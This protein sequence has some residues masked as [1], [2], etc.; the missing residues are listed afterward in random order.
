MADQRLIT[1]YEGDATPQ[2]I[3][4]RELPLAD[5]PSG[6]LIYLYSISVPAG[7]SG[8]DP[9]VITLYEN[10]TTPQDI[11]LRSL[12][13]YNIAPPEVIII[14]RN[15]LILDTGEEEGPP[16]GDYYGIL[17]R[18]TGSLWT[19]AVLKVNS[20]GWVAKPLYYWNGSEFL[21]IDVY[22]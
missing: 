14:L 8:N 7:P 22:G 12:P 18:W 11:V 17:K 3:I 10:D 21:E 13:N 2:N 5:I 16:S 19:K 1:L 20:G 6:P 15:P 4:L 9:R